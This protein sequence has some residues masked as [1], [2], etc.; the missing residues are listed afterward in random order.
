[1]KIDNNFNLISEEI[2]GTAKALHR[3]SSGDVDNDG[4]IDILNFPTGHPV[5]QTIE[6]RFP[7]ILYN[8]G[9]GNFTEELIFK[10]T[11]LQDYYYS[12]GST[13]SHLFDMDGDGFLDLIFGRDIGVPGE[14]LP[15]VGLSVLFF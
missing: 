12:M 10:N 9:V 7:T 2:V 15:F 3:G 6:Q 4:D 13:V 14:E 1:M 8:D 11:N 5:N